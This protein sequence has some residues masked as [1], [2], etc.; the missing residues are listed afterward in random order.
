MAYDGL[1]LPA[2]DDP[3]MQ[4]DQPRGERAVHVQ[5]LEHFRTTLELKCRDLTPEQVGRRAVPP[6]SLSLLGMVR[7][8][9]RVEH[10]WFRRV[11]EGRPD[12][13]K[14]FEGEDGGFAFGE[15]TQELVDDAFSRWR[16]EVTHAR[17]VLSTRS[18]DE[19]V[20]VDGDEIE[21][22]D[23]VVHLIEEYARHCGHVDLLRECIDGRTGV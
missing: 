3:R 17:E 5:Y 7:H 11:L 13:P 23:V 18:P 22:R 16:A 2:S 21:V 12:L 20:E 9:A 4:G 6:S 8:L 14:L 1:W 15:P 19:L 10:S